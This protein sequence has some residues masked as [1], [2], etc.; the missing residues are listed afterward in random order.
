MGVT[1]CLPLFGAPEH[2]LE[3]RATSKELRALADSL[4]ERLLRAADALDR[5]TAD[6]WSAQPAAFELILSHPGVASKEQ[7]EQRLRAAGLDPQQFLIVEDVEDEE[8][9]D[10]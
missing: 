1:V 7:A 5:L 2:E 6:G 3:E 9:L 8:D 10:A 4:R